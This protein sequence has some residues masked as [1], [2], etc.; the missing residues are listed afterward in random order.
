M[1]SIITDIATKFFLAVGVFVVI[2]ISF[3]VLLAYLF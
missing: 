2:G 1:K 3:G